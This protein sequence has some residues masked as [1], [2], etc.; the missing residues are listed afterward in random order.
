MLK[1]ALIGFLRNI[2]NKI[3]AYTK[4]VHILV[5]GSVWALF[6]LLFSLGDFSIYIPLV[7]GAVVNLL[8]S[9]LFWF[10]PVLVVKRKGKAGK[11]WNPLLSI[12]NVAL[13]QY[14]VLPCWSIFLFVLIASSFF[15]SS[16][17]NT[18]RPSLVSNSSEI[19]QQQKALQKPLA[20]GAESAFEKIRFERLREE[21]KN[22]DPEIQTDLGMAYSK[23]NGTPQELEEALKWYKLAAEQGYAR[24]QYNVGFYYSCGKGVAQD[25]QEALK[26]YKLAAEQGYVKAQFSIGNAYAGGKGMPQDYKEALKWYTLAAEQGDANAQYSIGLMYDNGKGMS[27]DYQ[28]ALKWY[29]LAAEQGHAWA[30]V[31]LAHIYVEGEDGV[32][33]DHEGAFKLY[34]LAAKQGD[35]DAQFY[36]G[37]CYLWGQGTEFDFDLGMMFNKL[38]FDGGSTT[39]VKEI[40]EYFEKDMKPRD[41]R[42]IQRMAKSWRISHGK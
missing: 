16:K 27:Q 20:W 2:S 34:A 42:K 19:M 38:A 23:G 5:Y 7:L 39:C 40:L 24:A 41:I 36:L 18:G 13:L 25:Y 9:G 21:G 37:R 6:L 4:Y 32:P 30:Q 10:L 14:V 1:S 15:G 22:G 12:I 17:E 33:Q 3:A 26:W 28:E 29:K 35:A 11:N 8:I 31:N